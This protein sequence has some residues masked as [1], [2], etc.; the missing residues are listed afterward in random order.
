MPLIEILRYIAFSFVLVGVV[1]LIINGIIRTNNIMKRA[2]INLIIGS[3]LFLI[4]LGSWVIDYF[5]LKNQSIRFKLYF[6]FPASIFV[7]TTTVSIYLFSMAKRYNIR[8]YKNMRK[9]KI[10]TEPV[11]ESFSLEKE[12]DAPVSKLN[13]QFIYL[14]FQYQDYVLLENSDGAYRGYIKEV[15]EKFPKDAT[16]KFINTNRLQILDAK[17]VGQVVEQSKIFYC[18]LINLAEDNEELPSLIKTN[19]YVLPSVLSDGIDKEIILRVLIGED[20]TI[21][22]DSGGKNEDSIDS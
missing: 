4:F 18:Y 7:I 17:Y 14:V 22:L 10:K 5:V 19:K 6:S 20:F 21:T 16:H 3:S 11:N 9:I 1:F 15:K 8:L 13:N 2:V 12:E